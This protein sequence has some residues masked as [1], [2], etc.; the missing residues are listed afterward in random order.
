MLFLVND[1]FFD[2]TECKTYYEGE[3]YSPGEDVL[4]RIAGHFFRHATPIDAEA[5]A[6]VAAFQ[7]PAEADDLMA[8]T[9]PDL[10]VMAEGLGIQVGANDSKAKIIDAIKAARD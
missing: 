7:S 5:K 10:M 3:S 6:A 8:K 1:R 9:K 4:K 2:S